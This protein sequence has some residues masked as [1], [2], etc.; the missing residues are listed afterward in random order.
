M[1]RG[2]PGRDRWRAAT[3]LHRGE[4]GWVNNF[5]KN[6]ALWVIIG[7]LLIALFIGLD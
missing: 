5:T 6:L 4:A 7:L 1:A 3:G 2:A